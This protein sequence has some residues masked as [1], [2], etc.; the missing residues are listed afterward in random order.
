MFFVFSIAQ[1]SVRAHGHARVDP[2]WI[3]LPRPLQTLYGHNDEPAPSSDST[4]AAHQRP[5]YALRSFRK[6]QLKLFQRTHTLPSVCCRYKDV[7]DANTVCIYST[8]SVPIP[9]QLESQSDSTPD[10]A[11]DSAAAAKPETAAGASPPKLQTFTFSFRAPQDLPPTYRGVVVKYFYMATV[12]IVIARHTAA[13]AGWG[14]R[15]L[16]RTVTRRP[17]ATTVTVT[18]AERHL[19]VPFTLLAGGVPLAQQQQFAQLPPQPTITWA[20]LTVQSSSSSNSSS[21]TTAVESTE[22]AALA[23]AAAL[24]SHTHISMW[25]LQGKERG[26]TGGVPLVFAIRSGD[27]KILRFMLY[28]LEYGPGD[29]VLG[30]FDLTGA[31]CPC[32]QI[33]ASLQMEEKSS[34][35]WSSSTTNAGNNNSSSSGTASVAATPRNSSAGQPQAA[36]AAAASAN[37]A[38]DDA[39]KTTVAA[40]VPAAAATPVHRRI[41]D[42]FHELTPCTLVS[43]LAL[44]LPADAPLSFQT[45]LVS[46]RWVL[47]FEFTIGGATQHT[48]AQVLTDSDDESTQAAAAA[49]TAAT[50]RTGSASSGTSS[51]A[52]PDS[53]TGGCSEGKLPASTQYPHSVLRWEV[54]IAVVP[55][56]A[57]AVQ[58]ELF[59]EDSAALQ[60]AVERR[61]VC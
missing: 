49:A 22:A 1:A 41:V 4:E 15:G 28:K 9:L 20:P 23:Q 25:D 31:D 2:R 34:T 19:H 14:V 51:S 30:T 18:Q 52:V 13:A 56:Q 35:A 5:R 45:D 3:A 27:A 43:S 36:A 24:L 60:D 59:T 21:S 12:S 40:V 42:V 55:P 26:G 53:S 39:T 61:A 57:S 6:K 54:P 46:V 33:C 38:A 32:Q 17:S 37:G 8:D 50:A 7:D 58:Q 11:A 29:V 44:A 47:K 10:A 16:L 48:G